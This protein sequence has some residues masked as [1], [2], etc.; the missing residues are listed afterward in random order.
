MIDAY[1]DNTTNGQRVLIALEELG[2]SHTV[3]R[4]DVRTGAHKQADYLK[5]N[6]T[7]RIPTIV[8]RDGPNGRSFVLTQTAAIVLYLADKAGLLIPLDPAGRATTLEWLMFQLTD[9]GAAMSQGYWL[10]MRAEPRHPE[11]GL[12]LKERAFTFLRFIDA[13]LSQNPFLA[14]DTYTVAD[15]MTFPGVANFE[16]PDLDQLVHLVRWRTGIGAR[17]AVQRA[18]AA[19]A[20]A[21]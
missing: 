20:A 1:L 8:D 14:G 4:I 11:A 16:H 2:L 21:E 12:A 18:L 19:L 9:L 6:P 7:G 13:R 10:R 3:H 5:L 17:P 15:L